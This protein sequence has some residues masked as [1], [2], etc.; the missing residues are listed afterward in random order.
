MAGDKRL[1]VHVGHASFNLPGVLSRANHFCFF[2]GFDGA[3]K[4]AMLFHLKLG[5][6]VPTMPTMGTAVPL[7]MVT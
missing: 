1:K 5:E 3:G 6:L 7:C 4:T 2:A